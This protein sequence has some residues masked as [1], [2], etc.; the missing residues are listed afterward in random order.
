MSDA[1]ESPHLYNLGRYPRSMP[2]P[3]ILYNGYLSRKIG[4][5]A[6]ILPEI[7]IQKIVSIQNGCGGC[8]ICQDPSPPPRRITAHNSV[9][10]SINILLIRERNRYSLQIAVISCI[11][12]DA[13]RQ[14][15]NY[16]ANSQRFIAGN[17]HLSAVKRRADAV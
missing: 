2:R 9:T 8:E 1:G 3:F 12:S 5:N 14:Y 10:S 11:L 17:R 4:I 13:A 6:S 7:W 15:Q 16:P